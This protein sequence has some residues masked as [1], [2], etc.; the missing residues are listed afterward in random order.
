MQT[1]NREH[2][3]GMQNYHESSTEITERLSW[4]AQLSR[5]ARNSCF[6][7]R[8]LHSVLETSSRYGMSKHI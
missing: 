8:D 5:I 7:D 2:T 3:P 6:S 1:V 4:K